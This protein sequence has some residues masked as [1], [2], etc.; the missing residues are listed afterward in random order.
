MDKFH[1]M[2]MLPHFFEQEG[3]KE[4]TIL[5][6][7]K[8]EEQKDEAMSAGANLVGGVEI[9][10]EIEVSHTICVKTVAPIVYVI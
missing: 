10:K 3:L 1:K 9:I 2:A 5:A 6:F 4:R 8:T 7:C